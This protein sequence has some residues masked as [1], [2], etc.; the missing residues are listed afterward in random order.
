[1]YEEQQQGRDWNEMQR[2]KIMAPDIGENKMREG[3]KKKKKSKKDIAF[4]G[5]LEL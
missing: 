3:K 4:F 1:M 2:R 5:F